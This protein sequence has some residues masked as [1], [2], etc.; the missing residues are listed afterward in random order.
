MFVL[1]FW[2]P[3]CQKDNGFTRDAFQGL[4]WTIN[5]RIMNPNV[6]FKY[7]QK[8]YWFIL[9][10]AVD[11]GDVYQDLLVHSI[12]PYES[13]RRITFAVIESIY[14]LSYTHHCDTKKAADAFCLCHQM[15]LLRAKMWVYL[16]S[17]YQWSD[18][19]IIHASFPP[20]NGSIWLTP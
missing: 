7:L 18:R 1:S 12:S 9:R 2:F 5:N 10:V 4:K 11:L 13:S 17:Q 6:P 16:G 14:S 8:A 3:Y 19:W 15:I 20:F